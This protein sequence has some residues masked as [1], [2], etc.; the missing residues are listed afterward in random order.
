M[1]HH[2]KMYHETLIDYLIHMHIY[3]ILNLLI[4]I[5][6]HEKLCTIK[7]NLPSNIIII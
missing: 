7:I 2:Q 4:Q 6:L 5:H 1:M 3:H